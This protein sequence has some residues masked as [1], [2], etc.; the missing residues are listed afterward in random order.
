METLL[1]GIQ[2]VLVYRWYF[3]HWNHKG[4]APEYLEWGPQLS[5]KGRVALEEKQATFCVIISGILEHEIDA[6]GL[7]PLPEKRKAIKDAPKQGNVSEFKSYL[8]L[9]S[10]Y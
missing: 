2:N 1:Q 5:E 9:L 3:S 4:I 7:H 6:Q 8:G 10:Y